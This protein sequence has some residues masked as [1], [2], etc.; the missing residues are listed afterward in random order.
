MLGV[1]ETRPALGLFLLLGAVGC[2]HAQVRV[3]YVVTGRVVDAQSSVPLEG[4]R[5]SVHWPKAMV[6]DPKL[7]PAREVVTDMYG[8]YLVFHPTQRDAKMVAG[9]I[10]ASVDEGDALGTALTMSC[11]NCRSVSAGIGK[12]TMDFLTRDPAGKV[13]VAG[14]V[15]RVDAT[16]ES[17]ADGTTVVRYELPDVPIELLPPGGPPVIPPEVPPT[18]APKTPAAPSP[19]A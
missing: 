14:S 13:V 8:R 17:L 18:P 11:P 2:S 5:V 16:L 19:D 1:L 10:P 7:P 4:V 12:D 15:T 3:D 9:F 6:A